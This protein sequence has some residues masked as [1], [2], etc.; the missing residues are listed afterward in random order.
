MGKRKES[1]LNRFELAELMLNDAQF[2]LRHNRFRCT[3]SRSYYAC[4]H[5]ARACLDEIGE[6]IKKTRA[7]HKACITIFSLQLVKT[8]ILPSFLGRTF[9]KLLIARE[10]A[11][12]ELTINNLEKL[13]NQCYQQA[14]AFVNEVKNYAQTR[15]Q[16]SSE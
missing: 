4:Y 11:D 15:K 12:Y 3:I 1:R 6:P 13:A 8:Q 10:T 14:R 16:N 9:R 7:T 5:S 2:N